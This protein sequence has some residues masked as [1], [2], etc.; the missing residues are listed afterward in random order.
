M[1]WE[2]SDRKSRLPADWPSRRRRV[3]IRDGYACQVRSDTGIKCGAPSNE[4]DHIVRGDDH[5]ESNLQAICR[6]HH[7]AK[8]TA[9]AAEA[10]REKF[11]PRRRPAEKHPGLS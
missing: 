2:T 5:R 7:A 10:R 11:I 6:S 9:E 3:L 4:V 1:G 8:T